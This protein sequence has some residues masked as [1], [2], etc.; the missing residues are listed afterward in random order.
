ML[1]TVSLTTVTIHC[2]LLTLVEFDSFALF[3]SLWLPESCSAP[4]NVRRQPVY[5]ACKDYTS[6]RLYFSLIL[7]ARR[8]EFIV[9]AAFLFQSF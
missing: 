9:L 6:A 5:Q 4:L 8:R 3:S 7:I 2:P 1:L